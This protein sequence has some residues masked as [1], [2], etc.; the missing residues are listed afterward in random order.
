MKQQFEYY[1][2]S[3]TVNIK[4]ACGN[5]SAIGREFHDY[6]EIVYFIDG[7]SRLISKD[8][9]QELA[10]GSIIFI[11]KES[12]HQFCM[13]N[14]EIYTRCIISFK[15]NSTLSSLIRQVMTEIRIMDT[16]PADILQIFSSLMSVA[17]SNLSQEEKVLFAQSVLVQLL[18]LNKLYNYSLVNNNINISPV[19][20]SAL[21]Y[22]DEHISHPL[23]IKDVSRHLHISPSSLAH[24]FKDELNISVYRYISEKRLSAIRQYVAKGETLTTAAILCGF[25]DYSAFYRMY[26]KHYK[27]PP[28]QDIK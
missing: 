13:K 26:K 3:D 10:T 24:K 28:S 15:E 2:N 11:P 19:I 22:I 4:Y 14:P 8:I 12:F 20:S 23:T 7:D 18:T 21:Y 6:D 27:N 16:P 17:K 9:Q 1:I 25:K 5:P